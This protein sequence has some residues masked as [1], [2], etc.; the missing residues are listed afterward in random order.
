MQRRLRWLPVWLIAA[1]GAL[2]GSCGGSG[3]PPEIADLT[4][5]PTTIA[6]GMQNTIAGSVT[7]TDAE[8]DLKEVVISVTGP[9]GATQEQ[10]P[11]ALTSAGGQ[12]SGTVA[13]FLVIEPR[14]AGTYTFDV[15][16]NDNGGNSS[17]HLQGTLAAQ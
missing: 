4:Y 17:N 8:G 1:A 10:P 14:S 3:T 6:V 12:K 2:L 13:M 15:W 7:F 5:S 9:E 16:L 11:Q